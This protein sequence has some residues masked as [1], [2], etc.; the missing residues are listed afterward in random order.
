MIEG[1][2]IIGYKID[3]LIDL[4]KR[5]LVKAFSEPLSRD[6]K[7]HRDILK[8]MM[9]TAEAAGSPWLLTELDNGYHCGRV[10]LW[11][12]NKAIRC[13]LCRTFLNARPLKFGLSITHHQLGRP[14]A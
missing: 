11:K 14:C 5:G 6:F 12:E 3:E 7:R 13:K 9:A 8:S 4:D 2:H 1:K 10:V